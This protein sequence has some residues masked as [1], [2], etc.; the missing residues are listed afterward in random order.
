MTALIISRCLRSVLTILAVLTLVFVFLRSA[1][2]PAAILL[3]ENAD[4]T[5]IELYRQRWGLD[6]PLWQQYVTYMRNLAG[7]DFGQSYVDGRNALDVVLAYL[8]KT[9]QLGIGALALAIALGIPAGVFAAIHQGRWPDRLVMT[10][11]VV[12]HSVP[13]FFV[14]LVLVVIFS[15]FLRW[16]P[17]SGAGSWRHS[18]MPTVTLALWLAATLARVTRAAVVE[19]LSEPYMKTARAKG[20]SLSKRVFAHALPNAAIPIV[21]VLGLSAGHLIAGAVIVETVFA[22]PGIGRL[23]VTAVASRELALVQTIVILVAIA[24][25][26]SSLVVDVLYGILD[27]RLRKASDA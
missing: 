2:D 15:L 26:T 16:L 19:A 22:W 6:K 12:G 10:I 1:G 14:G 4:A 13:A 9:L 23:T 17:S 18:L 24:M 20:L 3:S 27:P 21:T 5:T 11:A 7:G 25:V 8:P